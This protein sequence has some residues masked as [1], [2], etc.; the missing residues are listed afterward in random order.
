[1]GR[2]VKN[3]SV[4]A[5]Q[6]RQA[7]V[8]KGKEKETKAKTPAKSAKPIKKTA[9]KPPT[10]ATKVAKSN[11]KPVPISKDRAPRPTKKAPRVQLPPAKPAKPLKAVTPKSP[12]LP[13]T[14]KAE[15]GPKGYTPAEYAKFKEWKE[16]FEDYS[17]QKLK[18]LLRSNMQ[19][20]TGN[21]DDLVY[22]CADGATLGRI[23]RCPKCFG[24]RPKFDF[25]KG[26][27]YCSG[28]RDDEDFKN[29]HSTFQLGEIMR[30]AWTDL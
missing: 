26:T 10:K 27:Y 5:K 22:K 3:T 4:K 12:K 29:C 25:K 24:G 15:S 8:S 21:K 7:V 23:P 16:K 13:K 14:P 30:D 11:F 1:M 28:Y 18:D 19:S 2:A 9:K 17:N 20:M 6:T